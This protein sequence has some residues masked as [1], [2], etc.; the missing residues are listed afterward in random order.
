[1]SLISSSGCC[2][3]EKFNGCGS[4]KEE[5]RAQL[6]KARLSQSWFTG[7]FNYLFTIKGG[8][9]IRL[10]FKEKTFVIYNLI[11]PQFCGKPPL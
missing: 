10:M 4:I 9:F 11:K 6:F 8:F 2:L 5:T 3:E 7:N 1:M